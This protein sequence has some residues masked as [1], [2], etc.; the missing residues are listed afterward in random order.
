MSDPQPPVEIIDAEFTVISDGRPEGAPE[1]EPQLTTWS[2]WDNDFPTIGG[3]ILGMI[4]VAG[5][6]AFFR[7]IH[8][9]G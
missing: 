7:A 8:W 5:V 9:Y 4:A 2:F 3:L 6:G 1:P